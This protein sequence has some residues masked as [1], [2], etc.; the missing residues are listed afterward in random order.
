MSASR[1]PPASLRRQLRKE[2][3]FGCP[4][5]RSPFL[6]WHHFDPPWHQGH[7][8]SQKGII[9]LCSNCHR[10]ADGGMYTNEQLHELKE[11]QAGSPPLGTL[12][13]RV[14]GAI[15][16]FGGNYFIARTNKKFSIKVANQEVFSFRL[17]VDGRLSVDAQIWNKRK[18]V[19]FKLERNDILAN[20][21]DIEDIE[22]AAQGKSLSVISKELDAQFSLRFDRGE[23]DEFSPTS[24]NFLPKINFDPANKRTNEHIA[25]KC[26][27]VVDSDGKLT[28]ITVGVK[29]QGPR[30][31]I[32][33]KRKGIILDLREVGYDRAT[34]TGKFVG[35]YCVKMVFDRL[36]EMFHMGSEES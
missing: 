30:F 28:V 7:T 1:T 21:D 25:K 14:K 24:A 31:H 5:C 35:E 18:E 4:I 13:W 8:H 2:V 19:V 10:Q 9:A 34:L 17:E 16:D 29:V 20:I 32:E 36:G 3:G 11:K 22:C 15:I 23:P 33:T 6:T 12:P 26:A 27:E